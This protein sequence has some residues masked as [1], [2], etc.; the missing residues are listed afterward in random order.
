[1]MKE[2]EKNAADAGLVVSL[3]WAEVLCHET[4]QVDWLNANLD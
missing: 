1:M 2:D 4:A 3:G